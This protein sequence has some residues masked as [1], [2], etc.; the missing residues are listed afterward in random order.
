MLLAR[1]C[2][3]EKAPPGWDGAEWLSTLEAL[4]GHNIDSV[5]HRHHRHRDARVQ[6]GSH[7]VGFELVAMAA[8]TGVAS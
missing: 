1:D 8:T 4:A 5:G 7:S 6:A 3:A 2:A